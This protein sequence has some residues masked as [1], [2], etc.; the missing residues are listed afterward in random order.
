M[1]LTHFSP[2]LRLTN[3]WF[4]YK[5]PTGLKWVKDH[6]LI[7]TNIQFQF[8]SPCIKINLHLKS[9]LFEV[10]LNSCSHKEKFVVKTVII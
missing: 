9:C 8:I 6:L 1:F 3:D 2:V 5:T 10:S 7:Q 4:L